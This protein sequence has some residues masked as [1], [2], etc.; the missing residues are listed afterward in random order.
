MITGADVRQYQNELGLTQRDFC[1]KLCM[2]QAALSLIEK[3]RTALSEEHLRRRGEQF[4]RTE[5][6]PCFDEFSCRLG[7]ASANLATAG[8]AGRTREG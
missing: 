7:E 2:S 5:F 1:E 8:S 3:G 4:G 6:D